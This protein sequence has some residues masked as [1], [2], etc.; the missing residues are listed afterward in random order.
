MS[1]NIHNKVTIRSLMEFLAG[2]ERL[3]PLSIR[4]TRHLLVNKLKYSYKK[5]HR[6]PK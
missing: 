1:K 3:A 6:L 4:E 2:I 5:A